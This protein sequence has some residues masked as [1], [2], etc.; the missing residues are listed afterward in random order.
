MEEFFAQVE[1][2][3]QMNFTKKYITI[4]NSYELVSRVSSVT[5]YRLLFV[6]GTTLTFQMIDLYPVV[7]NGWHWIVK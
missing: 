4:L 7:T 6:T 3:Q 1:R 5:R 2:Q